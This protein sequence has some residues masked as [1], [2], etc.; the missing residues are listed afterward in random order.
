MSLKWSQHIST[1][2]AKSRLNQSEKYFPE[3]KYKWRIKKQDNNL[4]LSVHLIYVT[5]PWYI[6]L[7]R[8]EQIDIDSGTTD[9]FLMNP[10]KKII[11]IDVLKYIFYLKSRFYLNKSSIFIEKGVSKIFNIWTRQ[12]FIR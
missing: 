1:R 8:A 11:Y 12:K 5:K 3:T 2:T 10:I 6:I 4:T 9:V 7:L